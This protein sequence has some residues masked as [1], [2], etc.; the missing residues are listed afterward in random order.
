MNISKQIGD[1]ISKLMDDNNESLR[2]LSEIIGI[3]HPTLKR[4]VDGTQPI[5]SEKLMK[6]SN[7]FGKSFEYFFKEDSVDFQFLF[8]ADNPNLK[9]SK[10]DIESFKFVLL[11]YIDIVNNVKFN[12]VP[13]SYN[14]KIDGKRINSAERDL[15]EKIAYEN[16]RLLNIENNIPENYYEIIEKTGINIIARDF[17]NDY[18]FGASSYSLNQGSFILINNSNKISEE[19]KIFSLI[20]EYAHLIFHREQYS[21][22]AV[23][24][25][26]SK[27]QEDINELIAN[28]F[29][30]YFL[31]PR[32]LVDDYVESRIKDIN[33]IEMK[34]YF[35]VSKQSLIRILYEYKYI[36]KEQYDDFWI[37]ISQN[38]TIKIEDFPL[39]EMSI[40]V[41]N[42]RLIRNIKDLYF[43]DNI[44]V[45]KISE[46]LGLNIIDIR[47]LLKK[48]RDSD[49][50]YI[51]L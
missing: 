6:I 51:H 49:E 48:W 29:A 10:R 3:S 36:D 46:I 16:R 41:K 28:K 24:Q 20:H 37:K 2:S 15:I 30:A 18:F 25:R 23:E 39:D 47:K 45:N 26:Y 19:R 13:H 7:Y 9:I 12:Y 5:D 8:R 17:D 21:D 27:S 34:R 38:D 43:Q 4:Y 42:N 11:N 14:L 22:I 1:R 31:M 50:L 32:N 33:L 44:S 40:E 35:K